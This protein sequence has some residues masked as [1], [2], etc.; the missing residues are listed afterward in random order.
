MLSV[1]NP[2]L[3]KLLTL[4]QS[5]SGAIS[6]PTN[7]TEAPLL[8]VDT[9]I[10]DQI[11]CIAPRLISED[12]EEKRGIWWFLVGSP[13]NGKSAIVGQ[14]VR[15][16]QAKHG[17]TF[18]LEK[19]HGGNLGTDI[20]ELD[21]NEIPYKVELQEKNKKYASAW[22]AQD[23]SVVSNPYAKNP[24][25][26]KELIELLKAASQKGVSLVVCANRGIVERALQIATT[27]DKSDHDLL[28]FKALKAVQD[29]SAIEGLATEGSKG[30]KIVFETIN[31]KVTPLDEGSII[32]NGSLKKLVT[33]AIE[34]DKWEVCFNCQSKSLCPFRNNRDWLKSD[35]GLNRFSKVLRYAEL[36]TGQTIVFREAVAIIALVLAGN[37][38]DY[39]GITPCEWVHNKHQA[40]ALFSLLA[41]R[42]YMIIF[43]SQSPFGL[44]SHSGDR[45]AQKN[46]ISQLESYVSEKTKQAISALANKE[47]AVT[48][49]VGPSRL[50]GAGG[51]FQE[52]DPVKE[53]QG[54]KLEERWNIST[55]PSDETVHDQP[56]I[57]ALERDCI[58]IWHELEEK[59][60]MAK[61]KSIEVYNEVR[62]WI[63]S[64]TY[65][66][67]FLSEGKLLFESDLKDY[68]SIS[69]LTKANIK[70]DDQKLIDAFIN[71]LKAFLTPLAGGIKISPVLKIYGHWVEGEFEPDFDP[72]ETSNSRLIV[73]IGGEYKN[74]NKRKFEITPRVY[75]WLSRRIASGLSEKTFPPY[76]HQVVQDIRCRAASGSDYAFVATNVSLEISLPDD[77]V[78]RVNRRKG[79]DLTK[80]E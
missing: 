8:D 34:E 22:F 38:A 51:I 46:T 16:M 29:Q 31:I 7:W 79:N 80:A 27:S 19:D 44:R 40:G 9:A 17:A 59:S 26:A 2:F 4:E 62:R 54:K 28:W 77:S 78:W 50:L 52:L 47:H 73:N 76:V 53:N 33:K 35:V 56:L 55:D 18:R 23:A 74:R 10:D 64:V 49:D 42:I 1:T 43:K 63:T 13:G 67:G 15:T 30:N 41:R 65:R 6:A 12:N 37:S 45:E 60:V 72:P 14:L 68:Q 70:D 32:E 36:M 25:S 3:Q 48:V 58:K 61:Y 71:T 69:I 57:T 24:D 11:K 20:T 66:L 75:T 39:D 21:E 5:G